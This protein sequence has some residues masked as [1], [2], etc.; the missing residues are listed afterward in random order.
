VI[1]AAIPED[2]EQPD[3]WPDF[4]ALLPHAQTA[5]SADSDGIQQI[6][7]Y[8]GASGSYAAACNLYKEVLDAR[9][10][11]LSPQHPD[12]LNTQNELAASTGY[13]GNA[14]GARDQFAVLLPIREQVLGPERS[15]TLGTR[16]SLARWTG[17]AG[18]AAGGRR[19]V[20]RA[21]AHPRADSRPAAP[22]HPGYS[23]RPGPL[24]RGGG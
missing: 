23:R 7:A 14:A 24:D 17:H 15:D 10:R 1:E 13:A 18:N 3:S 8:L 5:L 16:G 20:G 2:P 19:P 6:A 11:V 4:T 21:V 9:I 22:E 12:T